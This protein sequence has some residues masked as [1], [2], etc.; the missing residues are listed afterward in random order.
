MQALAQR[1]L[2]DER[3]ELADHLGVPAGGEVGVDRQLGR[4]QPQLLEPADL[5]RRER[6]VGQVRERLAA[7]QR[8]R[9]A[10][11]RLAEQPLG[12]HRVDLAVRE[13]QLVAATA[14]HDSDPVAVEHAAQVRDVELHHLRRA[15][16]QRVAPQPL[17]Q[18][19]GRHRPAR[20]QRE[21]REH[22]PLLAGAQLDRARPRGEP[23]AALAAARSTVARP[24]RR[25]IRR[26]NRRVDR[27]STALRDRRRRQPPDRLGRRPS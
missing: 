16:R 23:R 15:R 19:I 20:L 18:A 11:P 3:V 10:R 12:A 9:L 13:L 6:L 26:V 24:Y 27:P 17:G 4:A 5:G 8:Q 2:R 1:V 22:R 7:P 14:G 25:S 21:H